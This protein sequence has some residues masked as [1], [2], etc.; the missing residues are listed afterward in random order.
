MPDTLESPIRTGVRT[1]AKTWAN[2]FEARFLEAGVVNYDDCGCGVNLLSH[3]TIA[4]CAKSFVGRPV[5]IRHQMVTPETMEPVAMGYI[6]DVWFNSEDGWWWCSGTI[7][8]EE[9]KEAIRKGAS[10]SCSYKVTNTAD[11][12]LYHNTKYNEEISAFEGMHLAIVDNPRY[13]RAVIRLN[14]KPT[15]NMFKWFKKLQGGEIKDNAIPTPEEVSGDSTIEIEGKQVTVSALVE[16]HNAV[17]SDEVDVD[18]K[19]IKVNDLVAGYKANESAKAKE[20]DEK[21][22]RDNAAKEEEE[23]KARENEAKAKEDEEKK[24]RDNA[25][26]KTDHFN[27]LLAARD[28]GF[29]DTTPVSIDTLET[30]LERGQNR[31]SLKK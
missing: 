24:A 27:D 4:Q 3:E 5:I 10:V 21:K 20:E 23:K 26:P 9:A 2:K 6:S 11:G 7:H 13:E 29:D 14:S 16:R 28:N 31:Y 18:G 25:A 15:P 8:R 30:R 22:A 12:G 17:P 19:K 1:N